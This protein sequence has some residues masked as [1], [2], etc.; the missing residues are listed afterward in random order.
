MN[1]R[2]MRIQE[3]N[4][5]RNTV[6]SQIRST[7]TLGTAGASVN[8]YRSLGFYQSGRNTS[9]G[10]NMVFGNHTGSGNLVS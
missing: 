6:Q 10:N 5:I 1:I 3:A 2:N 4:R 7:Q 8:G 9:S